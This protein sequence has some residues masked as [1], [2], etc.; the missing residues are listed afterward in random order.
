MEK[1]FAS[2][3]NPE[4][5]FHLILSFCPFVLLS[6]PF[7]DLLS[8]LKLTAWL[9]RMFFIVT[10]LMLVDHD[11]LNLWLKFSSLKLLYWCTLLSPCSVAFQN[12]G[13]A[14]IWNCFDRIV[15]PWQ[16]F[17]SLKLPYSITLLSRCLV[18]TQSAEVAQVSKSFSSHFKSSRNLISQWNSVK[19]LSET[20]F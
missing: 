5:F 16:N 2:R 18:T 13:F 20:T 15:T 1:S 9:F 17:P 14:Q 8:S 3:K 10:M 12:F 11:I 19:Q 7:P 6:F 4:C